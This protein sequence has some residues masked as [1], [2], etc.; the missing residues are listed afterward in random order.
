MAIAARPYWPGRNPVSTTP[1]SD[2][3]FR[4]ILLTLSALS[5]CR[6]PWRSPLDPNGS[7]ENPTSPGPQIPEQVQIFISVHTRGLFLRDDFRTGSSPSP[8]NHLFSIR[9]NLNGFFAFRAGY[10]T[11]TDHSELAHNTSALRAA[12]HFTFFLLKQHTGHESYLPIFFL[13]PQP[14]F[15]MTVMAT[16]WILHSVSFTRISSM[17]GFSG[18]RTMYSLSR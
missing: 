14:S 1:G 17:S 16:P 13:Y 2:L 7:G 10:R 12:E 11:V 8:Y 6:L 4:T 3:P 18:C 9:P 15:R 5:T